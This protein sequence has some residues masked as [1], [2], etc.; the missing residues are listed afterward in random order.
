MFIATF[1]KPESRP[2]SPGCEPDIVLWDGFQHGR[3]ARSTPFR[4]AS[5][6]T[7][8]SLEPLA[9]RGDSD[10]ATGSPRLCHST[11]E[12]VVRSRR[13]RLVRSGETQKIGVSDVVLVQDALKTLPFHGEKSV[14]CYRN[15]PTA[16]VVTL[17]PGTLVR[18]PIEDSG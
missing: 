14:D 10:G 17:L 11:Q 9:R 2:F 6:S 13:G 5:A 12:A 4:T 8:Q 1:S 3:I 16:K 7:R 15:S 18:I